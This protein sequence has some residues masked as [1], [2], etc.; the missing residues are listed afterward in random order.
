MLDTT[1]CSKLILKAAAATTAVEI[2][3]HNC[4]MKHPAIK[5]GDARPRIKFFR[6]D[7]SSAMNC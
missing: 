7:G 4:R 6:S 1:V 5:S 3:G 2:C